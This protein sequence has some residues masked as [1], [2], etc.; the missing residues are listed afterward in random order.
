LARD[1]V[2]RRIGLLGGTFD[3]V[4]NAH[5]ALGRIAVDTLALNELRWVPA[6]TPWQKERVITPAEHRIA[7]LQLALAGESRF[8]LERCEVERA[9]PSYTLD[10]VRELQ[11]RE[12]G[13][14]WFLVIGQDQYANLPTW[15]GWQEL[16]SRVT[17]A[18]A[19]RPGAAAAADARLQGLAY[20]ALPLPPME[21][22]ASALRQRVAA[23]QSIDGWVPAEV[24]RYI[25]Q[26]AL[27]LR[28]G[29]QSGS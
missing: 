8:R 29:A 22:A 6:G 27:Y 7:M 3:P 21:I 18:V 28:D 12:S 15:H 17:L 1:A 19:A 23:G 10:T 20:Q 2:T 25:D 4:H 11:Q 24:A 13:T 9:G 14:A 16:L 26:H 5:L